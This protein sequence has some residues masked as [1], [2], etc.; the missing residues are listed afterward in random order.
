MKNID[1]IFD[2]IFNNSNEKRWIQFS[3]LKEKFNHINETTLIRN[4]NKL[5]IAEK[6]E[7]KSEWKNVFYFLWW[8]ELSIK[9]FK[10]PFFLRSEK[11]YNPKF[12][13]NYI[14]NKTN[15]LTK[16][17]E[18]I[19]LKWSESFDINTNYF[20]ENK[21]SLENLLI[22]LTFASSNLE[23]NTY[24]HLDTD[25]LINYNE[26]AEWKTIDETQM[27]LNHKKAIE[28]LVRYKKEMWFTQKS[29]FEIHTLLWVKL[30]PKLDLWKIREIPVEIWR[31]KYLPIDNKYQL[32]DEFRI[33]LEKL[34]QIKN[35]FEQ[36]LF[37]LVFIPYF[38]IF[39]DINKR[40]SRMMCNLPLLK[41][42]LWI[43]SLM[44]VE[45]KD[46]ILS[47]LA[48]YELNDIKLMKKIFIENYLLNLKRYA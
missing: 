34:N 16:K 35:P 2:Y 44:Q 31:S 30:L 47:I 19:L 5:L 14:P 29:F 3:E 13:G 36:S 6:I 23:W 40:T 8:F 41:N 25:V 4:L 42:N 15:F 24:S 22:D 11:K 9:Y 46:Y 48:I 28:Y 7:K 37:I 38:Q 1:K 26:I 12:L 21:R 32:E 33:F 45:K 43:I 27:I 20:K 39:L 17:D 10:Q 18:E